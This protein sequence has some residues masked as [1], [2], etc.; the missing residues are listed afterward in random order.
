MSEKMITC[1]LFDLEKPAEQLNSMW[2][3]SPIAT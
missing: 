2:P 3:P 1:L